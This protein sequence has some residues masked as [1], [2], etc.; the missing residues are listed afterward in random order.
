MCRVKSCLTVTLPKINMKY[1]EDRFAL[2]TSLINVG[3]TFKKGRVELLESIRFPKI[4]AALKDMISLPSIK[5]C[6]II[7]TC[8]RVE[9]FAV[10]DDPHSSITAVFDNLLNSFQLDPSV[11]SSLFDIRTGNEVIVH[12]LRLAS[13]LESMIIGEDQILGQVKEALN[14]AVQAG[15]VGPFLKLVFSRTLVCGR[16]VRNETRINKG[17]VSMGSAAV[18]LAERTLKT[19]K[20]KH[21]LVIGAGEMGFLVAKALKDKKCNALF[22]ANRTYGR[23]VCLAEELGGEAIRFDNIEKKMVEA[24]ITIVTTSAPHYIIRG[25]RLKRVSSM[26]KKD[27]TIIDIGN[28]RQVEDLKVSKI[29]SYN[30]D[31][32]RIIAEE[33][34]KKRLNEV[35]KAEKIVEEEFERL[36]KMVKK[37]SVEPLIK[38]LNKKFENVRIQE[39]ERACSFLEHINSTNE[40]KPVLED[41]SRA[42]IRKSVHQVIQTIRKAAE[43]DQNEIVEAAKL[44]F[45]IA[46]ESEGV[47]L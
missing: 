11:Y 10:S 14:M 33:N 2:P 4:E 44:I 40:I 5:E 20:D 26:R 45:N 13:G 12:G 17:A 27:L 22:I 31:N 9:I 38:A 7:Q 15:T 6:L 39:I 42:I 25:D 37:L 8:N 34:L 47:N 30:I 19:L 1:A 23:A 29:C 41:L 28:P 18:E 3:L 32:L 16:R 35:E 43:N 21:V 36:R 24:D 46:T